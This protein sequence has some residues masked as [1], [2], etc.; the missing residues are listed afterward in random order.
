MVSVT[1]AGTK[2]RYHIT[3]DDIMAKAKKLKSGNW[4]VLVPDYKDENGKW[5]YKS[6]TAPTKKEAEYTAA[7]FTHNNKGEKTYDNLTLKEAYERYIGIKRGVSSPSTIRG[8]E[9]YQNKYLQL[10]MPMKLRNITAELVQASISE[11]A[12]THSPKSVRNIYGLFHAVM[13]V[14]YRQL[15]LSKIRLPQKQKV[16]VAVPT[17]EQINTLLDFCDDY[18]RVPV[19][20]ASHGSLRRSEISALSPD[21]FTDFGVVINKSLVQDSGQNWIL[22]NTPKSFAGNRVVPLDREL[23]QECLKWNHFGINPGIIDD[24]FKKCRKNSELPYFKF[25]SLRHYFA[26]ELHAQGIPD[27]YIAEI[28]GWE[29]V[30]T[31]QRI[32]QHTLK[33]HADALTKKILNVFAYSNSK[34]KTNCNTITE[35]QA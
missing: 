2:N 17:T 19:L 5:H 12:V 18:V 13:G 22:K 11:L 28:G 7:E 16:E 8:Y 10:L 1:I 26:S 4:R 20:L 21:D 32:Y 27:K 33:D 23:I 3:G 31:L 14:Y 9:Q 34:I 15:D 30:E 35:K 25:H 24:H 29:N 6:F